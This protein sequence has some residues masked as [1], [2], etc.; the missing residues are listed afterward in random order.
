[1]SART[2]IVIINSLRLREFITPN[3]TNELIYV[4]SIF[5]DVRRAISICLTEVCSLARTN[6]LV[7]VCCMVVVITC[8]ISL[9]NSAWTRATPGTSST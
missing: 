3:T 2:L 1:M 9:T 8:H 7:D 5:S 4:S 6:N